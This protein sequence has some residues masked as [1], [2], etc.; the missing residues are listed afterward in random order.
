[1]IESLLEI[2][3]SSC[4]KLIL[5]F[6]SIT[7]PIKAIPPKRHPNTSLTSIDI[8]N[9]NDSKTTTKTTLLSKY[10]SISK[11]TSNIS[12]GDSLSSTTS[13]IQLLLSKSKAAASSTNKLNHQISSESTNNYMSNVFAQIGV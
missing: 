12:Q 9:T 4:F 8:C 5:L 3:V 11:S 7:K 13:K 6:N 1:M 2:F 10:K